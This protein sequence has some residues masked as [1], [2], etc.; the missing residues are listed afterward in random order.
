MEQ[1]LCLDIAHLTTLFRTQKGVVRAVDDLTLRVGKGELLGL[2][3][4]SG[5]GKSV[6]LLSILRLIPYPGEMVS[7][8]VLFEGNDLLQKSKEEMRRIRG[9][10]ISMVFQDPMTT[11]NPVFKVGEQIR[12]SLTIHGVIQPSHG[13]SL[14]SYFGDHSRRKAEYRHVID[15]MEQVGISSPDSRYFDYPHQFS[16]GMQQRALIAIAL[17]CNPSLI[18]ADEPTTALDVTIQAQILELLKKINQEHHTSMIF[19]THNLAVAHEFCHR[20]AVMY[21]GRIVE[22]GDIDAVV[23]QPLHPYTRGLLNSIPRLG[24]K[25]RRIESIPGNVPD[26]VDLPNGC[27]FKTRCSWAGAHCN[28]LPLLKDLGGGHTVRCHLF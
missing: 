9:M 28:E 6:T 17:S 26:L 5:C 13:K 20:I 1:P 14:L 27:A 23:R 15:L 21:A 3:G 8:K 19:V 12:E 2:V 11:L 22:V 25:S 10:K 4:E 18:L 7:G 16:G 24:D